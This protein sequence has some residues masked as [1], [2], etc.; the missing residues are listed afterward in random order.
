M[1]L[2]S[3]FLSSPLMNTVVA[4]KVRFDTTSQVELFLTEKAYVDTS[5]RIA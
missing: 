1:L 3:H 5:P 2:T 4:K